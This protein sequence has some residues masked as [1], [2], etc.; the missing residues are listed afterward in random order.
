M[1]L[2]KTFFKMTAGISLLLGLVFFILFYGTTQKNSLQYG[3][4]GF[5]VGFPIAWLVYF[6]IWFIRKGFSRTAFPQQSEKVLSFFQQRLH[7]ELT[8][9]QEK[10]LVE[11]AGALIMV[12]CA[13]AIAAAGFL[14][15]SGLMYFAGKV[16]W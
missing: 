10:L 7:L 3:L 14:V 16:S 1:R 6:V 9:Y 15:V 13:L 4:L 12:A 5:L 11:V 8:S 2:Q